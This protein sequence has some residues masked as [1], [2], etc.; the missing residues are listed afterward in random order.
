MAKPKKEKSWTDEQVL[1]IV[2]ANQLVDVNPFRPSKFG[3]ICFRLATE[4]KLQHKKFRANWHRF[5]L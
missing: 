1:T 2:K 3:N 4:G 5:Y